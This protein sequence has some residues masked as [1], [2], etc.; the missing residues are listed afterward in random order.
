MSDCYLPK[1]DGAREV[2]KTLMR[3]VQ[4]TLVMTSR[5]LPLLSANLT[6]AGYVLHLRSTLDGVDGFMSCDNVFDSDCFLL[7]VV[8]GVL[9]E[10]IV[11]S[12][13]STE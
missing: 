5:V 10:V 13:L 7:S 8:Y 12:M 11:R 2:I 3:S 1:E 9:R 4:T 6:G